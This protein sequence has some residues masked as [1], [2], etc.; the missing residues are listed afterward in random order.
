M[1]LSYS[2]LGAETGHLQLPLRGDGHDEDGE[3]RLTGQ[4]GRQQLSGLQLLSGGASRS[5]R[6]PGEKQTQP[7]QDHHVHPEAGQ[8]LAFT[9]ATRILQRP[10]QR[11]AVPAL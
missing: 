7:I 4:Q 5:S 11:S 1:F 8:L 2:L 10:P 9:Q 3:A 6:Q